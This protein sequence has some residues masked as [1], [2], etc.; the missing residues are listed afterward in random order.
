MTSVNLDTKR[1]DTLR[2]LLAPTRRRL[3][4]SRAAADHAIHWA[5][6]VLEKGL[7]VYDTTVLEKLMRDKTIASV[8][9]NMKAALEAF[10]KQ[11]TYSVVGDV[12]TGNME[13]T[14]RAGDESRTVI[15]I[16]GSNVAKETVQ[17]GAPMGA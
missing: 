2:Q 17:I 6:T 9:A 7:R 3:P 16:D 13:I 15:L 4:A 12:E 10:D 14:R 11:A 1:L 8:T 5:A